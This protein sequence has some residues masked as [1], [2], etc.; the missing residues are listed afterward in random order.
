MIILIFILYYLYLIT[1]TNTN[2]NTNTIPTTNNN[3]PSF[4]SLHQNLGNNTNM[5]D[6][7]TNPYVPPL[8]NNDQIRYDLRPI[9]TQSTNLEYKQIGILTRG[10]KEILPLMG[11]R[12]T[13]RYKWQYYTIIGGGNGNLQTKLPV[14][15]N[16]KS[17]T[18]EYGCDE[19]YNNDTVYVEGYKDIFVA[20]IYENNSFEY[21]L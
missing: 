20:T 19:I 1:T 9:A 3:I 11:R 21:V 18:G 5:N 17:C 14:S 15:V 10:D 12:K 2:T 4:F 16:G 8:R 7:L 6:P 13:S